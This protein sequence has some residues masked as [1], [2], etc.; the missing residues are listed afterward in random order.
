MNFSYVVSGIVKGVNSGSTSGLSIT[1]SCGLIV[2][3]PS[4]LTNRPSP[5]FTRP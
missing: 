3:T 1:I 5:T 4:L 2:I